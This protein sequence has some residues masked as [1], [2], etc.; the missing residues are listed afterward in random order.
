MK[1]LDL[2]SLTFFI[3]LEHTFFLAED[4][5]GNSESVKMSYMP[6]KNGQNSTAS[7]FWTFLYFY[8]EDYIGSS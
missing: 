2:I 1:M 5:I 4:Y 6:S 8:A 3:D 7:R